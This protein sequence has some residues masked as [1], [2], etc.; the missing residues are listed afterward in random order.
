[1]ERTPT[2]TLYNF[3]QSS[4][5]VNPEDVI[6]WLVTQLNAY[7]TLYLENVA[8]Q[9]MRSLRS[10]PSRLSSFTL[11]SRDVFACRTVAELNMLWDAFK[12]T[13][14]Y[15]QVNSQTSG[16]FS[17]GLA[18][19][20]RYLEHI[21]KI[22]DDNNNTQVAKFASVVEACSPQNEIIKQIL[23]KYFSNGFRHNS[24]IE[25]SR[26]RRFVVEDFG[27]VL[28]L[29]DE[30]LSKISISCGILFNEKVFVIGT[31][32][33]YK[34]KNEINSAATAGA[35][36]IFYNSFYNYHKE[37][38]LNE[39]VISEIMLKN[40]LTTL[41][42]QYAHNLSYISL[43]M[44]KDN[45]LAK[46]R[47]EVLRI[48]SD[49]IVLSYEQ[50]SERLPYIPDEKIKLALAQSDD[51]VWSARGVYTY[52]SKVDISD[53]ERATIA[54]H[55]ATACH[56]DG[57]ASLSDIPFDEIARRNPE[58]SLTAI[59]NATFAI[60][61]ASNYDRK[62]KIIA[63]KGDVLD[64]LSIMKQHCRSLEKC[65]LQDLL[66]F[67][68][69]LTGEAHRWISMEA[70]YAIMV[71]ADKNIYLAEKYVRFNVAEIDNALELFVIG[72]YMPL[73]SFITFV[74][75]P[76]C[77]QM[78][79]LFLLESYCRRFSER[80]RFASLSVN[81]RN[82]GTIVRR[83]CSLSYIETMADAVASSN[84]VLEKPI[85]E[86]YLYNNGYIGRRSYAKTAELISYAKTL[87]TKR[88]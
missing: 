28:T 47:R 49:D 57:H 13:P 52:T 75:F 32:T 82:A 14:N 41:Y 20:S 35:E 42:P 16:S 37:W 86:D 79:N 1:M 69:E 8:R 6:A 44:S 67:E 10:A 25:L 43:K 83:D 65:S 39:N 38:L 17:A 60:V 76:D 4:S 72:D 77:G 81:S 54:D 80:F 66:D 36:V 74:T 5:M 70:G 7:G 26:F 48:W 3:E 64:A 12:A 58:L 45:I 71:R 11:A 30:E 22:S 73:K 56:R 68:R 85:I 46:I 15:K 84:V 59:H 61:L 55:V 34:I 40:I 27:D 63:R 88:G 53:D 24:P 62:G 31:Y 9:Y 23:L 2:R 51:F 21:T 78:W 87:R 19:L 18:C 50:L 29:N 33:E